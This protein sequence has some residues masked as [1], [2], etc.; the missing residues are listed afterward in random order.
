[1]AYRSR[2]RASSARRSNR[3]VSRPASRGRARVRRSAR[4]TRRSTRRVSRARA[5]Q[6]IKIV[7]EHSAAVGEGMGGMEM[8]QIIGQTKRARF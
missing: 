8:P 2:S 5:P 6:T 4:T 1:M 7:L 3:R